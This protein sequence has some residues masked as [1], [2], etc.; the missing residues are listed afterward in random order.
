MTGRARDAL[1][2][3]LMWRVVRGLG[4]W[5][6]PLV[7]FLTLCPLVGGAM[8]IRMS[9]GTL[10]V[11]IV[12]MLVLIAYAAVGGAIYQRRF[13][14]GF[15]PRRSPERVAERLEAERVARRQQMLDGL[16]NDLR[17]RKVAQA[18]AGAREWLRKAAESELTGDVNAILTAGRSWPEVRHYPKFLEGLLPALVE[19]NQPALA[20]T[21]AEAGLAFSADFNLGSEKE[22]TTLIGYALDTSRPRTAAKMLENFQR[23]AGPSHQP[24]P[25]LMALRERIQSKV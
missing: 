5:Y 1:S 3:V 20:C 25:Q 17:V 9:S 14:L 22:V 7:V 21:V 2:L 6:L 10:K 4:P 8:A 16:Y 19:L 13:E 23:R 11:A 12:E 18:V 15:D 24:G